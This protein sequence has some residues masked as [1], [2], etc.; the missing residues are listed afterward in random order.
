[1]G[2]RIIDIKKHNDQVLR[3]IVTALGGRVPVETVRKRLMYSDDESL[4]AAL[5]CSKTVK[6][7][8]WQVTVR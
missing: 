6:M 5:R 7:R 3:A 2:Q 1:M 8:D 4:L